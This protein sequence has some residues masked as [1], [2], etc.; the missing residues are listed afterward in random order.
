LSFFI[1]ECELN[2]EFYPNMQKRIS[3]LNNLI[4][5]YFNFTIIVKEQ[6]YENI[7]IISLEKKRE[8][9]YIYRKIFYP[10][11]IYIFYFYEFL[12]FLQEMY[13]LMEEDFHYFYRYSYQE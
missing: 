5:V 12:V 1:E 4:I 11:K 13:N 6:L 7:M 2:L 9:T 8:I 3:R 10:T